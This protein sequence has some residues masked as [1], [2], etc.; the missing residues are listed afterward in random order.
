MLVKF[1]VLEKINK[2]LQILISFIIVYF[3]I[4]FQLGHPAIITKELLA[5]HGAHAVDFKGEAITFKATTSG[6]IN[7]LSHC[8]ELLTQ[9]EENW[10]RRLEKVNFY[11][12]DVNFD[13]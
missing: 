13:L 9:R 3:F 7:T 8:I 5:Q 10:K 4:I 11:Y 12:T 1:L 6:I 2:Q